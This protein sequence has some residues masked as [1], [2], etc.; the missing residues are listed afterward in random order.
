MQEKTALWERR[1][2]GGGAAEGYARGANPGVEERQRALYR[3]CTS[4]P[5]SLT[6]II[7][8]TARPVPPLWVEAYRYLF[9]ITEFHTCLALYCAR[10]VPGIYT[11][12][13]PHTHPSVTCA[14]DGLST[15]RS[16]LS[17]PSP[18]SP[19]CIDIL[20][21]SL[22]PLTRVL[23]FIPPTLLSSLTMIRLMV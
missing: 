22:C 7:I 5:L 8:R 4:P 10:R 19:P 21:L 3:V 20:T 16:I 14:T 15:P 11:A 18:L 6:L 9:L 13:H 23:H 17:L 12:T 1:R 2:G